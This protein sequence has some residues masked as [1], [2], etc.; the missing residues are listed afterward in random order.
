M[1]ND[2]LF[3]RFKTEVENKVVEQIKELVNDLKLVDKITIT[4]EAY[5]GYPDCDELQVMVHFADKH[6]KDDGFQ[7]TY[8]LYYG[9]DKENK[10][11]IEIT[12]LSD[13]LRGATGNY[14]GICWPQKEIKFSFASLPTLDDELSED[15]VISA[16]LLKEY[17]LDNKLYAVSH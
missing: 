7:L 8:D 4:T 15:V 1:L 2:L 14:G 16:L 11:E 9:D 17:I 13:I 12:M 6:L 10:K 3:G 5:D